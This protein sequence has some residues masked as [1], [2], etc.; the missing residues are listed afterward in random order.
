MELKDIKNTIIN[1]DCLKIMKELPKNSI[2]TLIT[3]PPYGLEFMGQKWDKFPLQDRG[4]RLTGNGKPTEARGFAKGVNYGHSEKSLLAYQEF[5]YE[6]AKEALRV[7]KPGATLL[8]FGSPRTYHRMAC[9]IEDAGWVI[10]DCIMWLYSTGFPKATDI[11][12]S[13]EKSGKKMEKWNG[14]KSHGLK[15]S[16][17]PIIWAQKP[18]TNLSDYDTII[19][20]LNNYMEV[21]L[22]QSLARLEKMGTSNLQE[23]ALTLS[24]IALLWRNILEENS[25]RENKF[26]ILT[27]SNLI[28]EL[29]TL[30]FLTLE[31]MQVRNIQEK[32]KALGLPLSVYIAERCLTEEKKNTVGILRRIVQENAISELKESGI[33][34]E[35][36]KSNSLQTILNKLNTVLKDATMRI[37]MQPEVNYEPILIAM[38]PNEGSY[39]ENALKHGVAGLNIDGGRIRIDK[40]KEQDSRVGTDRVR[41]DKEGVNSTSIFGQSK[42]GVQMYK[43][44]GRFPA[45]I[46]LNEEAAQLLDK[47]SGDRKGWSSQKHNKFNPYGGN[48]LLKSG[49]QREGFYEGFNDRGGASRFFYCAKASRAER[50]MGCDDLK[51]GKP[52]RW[53]KGGKWTN[54]TTPSKNNHPTIKPLK[55]MEYLC[56]LTKT[57]T[58]GIVL[59]PFAGSGTTGIACK[60]IGRDYILI[61]KDKSYCEIAK[62]R[63]KAR[64]K[65]LF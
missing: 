53:N 34:A 19:V 30:R 7:A 13:G 17:E 26:I 50:Q 24:N 14:W 58:G 32:S 10:K 11:K 33:F 37:E 8:C 20:E 38:K 41:G 9:G 61:E 45:N 25:T 39:A 59:D 31:N 46:I 28:T 65:P 56:I 16:Y 43:D 27:E 6:W 21:L 22:W 35:I 49:T 57:P 3:D 36:V 15:P 51:K 44:N 60:K 29:R 62:A 48:A 47:Q 40:E 2:D 4:K 64:I 23:M 55:L 12:K 18:L 1:G 42:E 54:D 52:D 63:I 5:S